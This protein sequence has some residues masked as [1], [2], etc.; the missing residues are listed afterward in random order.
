M[1]G[2]Q[3]D[4]AYGEGGGQ[5]LR[6]CLALSALTGQRLELVNIRAGRPK[7][8]LRPQHLAAVRATAALCNA[9]V[10]GDFIHS[11]DLW[12]EPSSPPIGGE[13]RIDV[14]DV[15]KGGSAGSVTLIAHTIFLPLSFS[16]MES[17]VTLC[18]GTHVPW[19]PSFSHFNDVYIP[20]ITRAGVK[21][22]AQIK[23]WGWYPIGGGE[24]EIRIQP[25]SR[26]EKLVWTERESL[27]KVS[28]VAAVT[29][30]PSHIP[31]RMAS[32]SSSILHSAGIPCQITPLRE[33]GLGPGA[34]IFLTAN[35]THGK[36]GFSSLGRKGLPSEK[37]AENVCATFLTFHN[38]SHKAAVD[39]YLA[40]QLI[41]PLALAD[42]VSEFTT[43][44]ISQHTLT[45]SYVIQQFL[46]NTIRIDSQGDGGTI[47]IEGI[48]YH[49]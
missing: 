6:T 36:V 14:R 16:A 2:I 13:Y 40:D 15:T 38:D 44:R 31:Q 1:S 25:I 9:Q 45:N 42:G 17:K 7:P 37:V 8:G 49:V 29:N 10:E 21:M 23:T 33:R 11:Q 28:G 26:L 41:L 34:G 27:E 20:T 32:R 48:G 12:F 30:L 19:S 5:V 4:G 43:T 18:G 35:Y 3:I 39:P 47:I 22:T 24:F 46:G